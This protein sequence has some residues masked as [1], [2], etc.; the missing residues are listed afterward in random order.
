MLNQLKTKQ[1]HFPRTRTTNCS[2][3]VWLHACTPR[4]LAAG[5]YTCNARR[6]RIQ[7]ADQRVHAGFAPHSMR[8]CW[9]IFPVRN[10]VDID[11]KNT[12]T[13]V[14][15]NKVIAPAAIAPR[16]VPVPLVRCLWV[17]EVGV[18]PPCAGMIAILVG[19]TINDLQ[20]VPIRDTDLPPRGSGSRPRHSCV[21]GT[22]TAEGIE[23]LG[24]S[25]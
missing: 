18:W 1:T 17:L 8:T 10:R 11:H 24:R 7:R 9:P 25:G 3:N 5:V 12:L 20:H 22:A 19:V 6:Y 4:T 23:T 15:N 14:I 2:G 21:N 16:H 13:P